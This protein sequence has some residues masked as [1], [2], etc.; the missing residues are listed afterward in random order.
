MNSRWWRQALGGD[1]GPGHAWGVCVVHQPA[2]RRWSYHRPIGRVGQRLDPRTS[3]EGDEHQQRCR[4][5]SWPHRV[6]FGGAAT[7]DATNGRETLDEGGGGD[8]NSDLV[9]CSQGVQLV[10]AGWTGLCAVGSLLSVH[11][12]LT[13]THAHAHARARTHTHI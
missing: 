11:L 13:H 6:G 10:R 7:G 2:A 5:S 12:C 9:G 1:G 8:L 3:T 4:W